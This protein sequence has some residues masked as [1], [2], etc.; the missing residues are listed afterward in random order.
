M[1]KSSFTLI[2]LIFIGLLASASDSSGENM[3]MEL[4]DLDKFGLELSVQK[5]SDS[6]FYELSSNEFLLAIKSIEFAYQGENGSLIFSQFVDIDT[7]KNSLHHSFRTYDLS[8]S[9]ELLYLI[10]VDCKK[11]TD[12]TS[13]REQNG[14]FIMR[15]TNKR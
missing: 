6:T 7:E 5:S 11:M 10:K 1:K 3:L 9:H 8:N 2:F 13:C 15:V 14:E 4:S 12:E